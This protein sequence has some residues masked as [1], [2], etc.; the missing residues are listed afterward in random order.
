MCYT[1]ITII[2]S[3]YATDLPD[4][5]NILRNSRENA[6]SAA[7]FATARYQISSASSLSARLYASDDD[8]SIDYTGSSVFTT[9]YNGLDAGGTIAYDVTLP[10]NLRLHADAGVEWNRSSVNGQ[11]DYTMRP[12]ANIN[13]SYAPGNGKHQLNFI[14]NYSQYSKGISAKTPDEIQY[15]EFLYVI[16]NPLLKN[17][18]RL[19]SEASYIWLPANTFNLALAARYVVAFDDCLEQYSH[20]N[21][22]G[23]LLRSYINDGDFRQWNLIMQAVYRPI[24]NLRFTVLAV[25]DISKRTSTEANRTIHPFYGNLSVQYLSLIH[26]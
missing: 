11:R 14:A 2:F 17:V 25:Y 23:A 26:I 5:Q 1:G 6:L 3:L 9:D 16:G 20:Y 7:I 19:M 13:A 8:N 4:S 21:E 10:V 24:N 18:S 15:N 22:G 12:T